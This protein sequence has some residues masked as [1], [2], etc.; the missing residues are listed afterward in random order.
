MSTLND[1]TSTLLKSIAHPTRISILE[2]LREENTLCVCTIYEK[3]NLEQSNISQHLK[4]L[5]NTGILRSK[6]NGL[7]V[8][9]TVEYPE[10]FKII[11]L[12]K[13]IIKIE[14]QKINDQFN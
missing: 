1:I 12:A 7:Q 10:I 8:L 13:D 5:K 6:K 9:Y 11:D 14:A 2:L 4:I 3:L